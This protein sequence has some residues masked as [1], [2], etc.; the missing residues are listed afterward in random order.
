MLMLTLTALPSPSVVFGAL[1]FSDAIAQG[2]YTLLK[3]SKS[4]GI[5]V[6]GLIFQ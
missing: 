3:H 6:L 2:T 5:E 4:G 1:V